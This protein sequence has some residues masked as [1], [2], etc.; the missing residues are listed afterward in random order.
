MPGTTA[1]PDSI[2]D[3]AALIAYTRTGDP[4]AFAVL[5]RRYGSMVLATCRRTLRN[6]ADA[7][8]A[9]Q[10]TFLKLAQQAS[11]IRENTGAWLHAAA[12]TTSIDL[13]RRRGAQRRAEQ[14]ATPRVDAAQADPTD[15]ASWRDV[16]PL[17]DDA[18]AELSD[19]D[20][21]LLVARFLAG[22]SLA[23]I[24]ESSGVSEGTV[25]RRAKR[26]LER[27]RTVMAASGLALGGAASLEAILGH[28]AA[29]AVSPALAATLGKI[30]L[31]GLG[32]TE[33]GAPT[34]KILAGV[35]A[36]VA[37]ITSVALLVA[38][39][40][41]ISGSGQ[42]ARRSTDAAPVELGPERPSRRTSRYS[43]VST[44]DDSFTGRGVFIGARGLSIGHGYFPETGEN[45]R[46]FIRFIDS[47]TVRAEGEPDRVIF[48][49]VVDSISPIDLPYGR[50]RLGQR[51]RI[52]AHFD[53]WGR[54]VLQELD[55]EAQ[56]GRNEPSWYGVRPPPGWP[57]FGQIPDEA[58][59]HGLLGP[60]AEAERIPLSLSRNEIRLGT[61][62][63]AASRFRIIEWERAEGYSRVLAIEAGGRNPRLIGTRIKLLIREEEDGYSLGFF[64][65]GSARA[66]SFPGSFE[67]SPRNPLRILRFREND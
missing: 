3:T 42:P 27:L 13:I 24:A 16:E 33:G 10:D 5:I 1:Y 23:D 49:S 17:I 53:K 64:E 30:G 15:A 12:M 39:P 66:D 31:A 8:D 47:E 55:G 38:T 26:A 41:T 36:T 62:V 50:F 46:A 60:W 21:D 56:L 40:A 20:R 18:L 54:L 59:P 35:I 7:E 63:W 43:S 22:R 34:G 44:A 19:A 6:N 11:T 9:A 52:E 14:K 37:V 4:D 45:I 48:N 61:D 51:L 29:G 32:A 67:F 25:S 65:P 28:A 58:G 2:D 57:E